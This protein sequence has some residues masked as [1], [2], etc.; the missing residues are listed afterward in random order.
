MRVRKY[1]AVVGVKV[2]VSDEMVQLVLRRLLVD[3]VETSGVSLRLTEDAQSHGPGDS[4]MVW[5]ESGSGCGV[6]VPSEGTEDDQLAAVADQV[7]QIVMEERWSCRRNPAAWPECPT[8]R[9]HPLAVTTTAGTA[10]WVCPSDDS[11]SVPIGELRSRGV[12]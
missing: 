4:F 8:H 1:R 11:L 7:Q 9:T 10:V 12:A 2:Q 3:L 6:S 5:T